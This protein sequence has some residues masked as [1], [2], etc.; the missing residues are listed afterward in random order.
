MLILEN[1]LS[2]GPK[3]YKLR[4]GNFPD[5][6]VNKTLDME[7]DPGEVIFSVPAQN[8]ANRNHPGDAALIIPHLSQVIEDPMYVGDDFNNVGKI[9]LV[10]MIPNSGG[11]SALI[12]VTV[13]MDDKG[14]YNICSS[15]LITQSELDKKR[16]KG[17]LK[18]V[19][20]K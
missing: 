7:V 13:E 12:A 6:I 10:R 3:L 5:N 14:F 18:N 19:K 4:P 17:I 8:H 1:K 11:K 16:T 15:Y 20:K 9:E 2:R